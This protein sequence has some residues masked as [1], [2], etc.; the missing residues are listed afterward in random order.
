MVFREE[1]TLAEISG[2]LE[3]LSEMRPT[4]GNLDLMS[5]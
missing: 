5:Q 1:F 3:S 2:D 4:S